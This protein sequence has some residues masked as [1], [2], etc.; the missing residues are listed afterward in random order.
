MARQSLAVEAT[1]R[2][3]RR[4]RNE[5]PSAEKLK[6]ARTPAMAP[7]PDTLAAAASMLDRETV[8]QAAQALLAHRTQHQGRQA[9]RSGGDGEDVLEANE[10]WVS[11]V[12]S[13]KRAPKRACLKPRTIPLLHP[14][15]KEGEDDVCFFVKDPQRDIKDL[16]AEKGVRSVTKVLGVTKLSKRYG[17]HEGKREL[18]QLYDLFLVDDRVAKMMPRLLGNTF[19]RGKKMPLVVRMDRDV[20]GGIAKALRSTSFQ[21]STGTTCNLRVAKASF[22]AEEIADNVES[23]VQGVA[24]ALPGEW[25]AFQGL[26]IKTMASPSLPIFAGIPEAKD[27]VPTKE[28]AEAKYG[29]DRL[30]RKKERAKCAKMETAKKTLEAKLARA[31]EK[32]KKKEGGRVVLGDDESEEDSEEIEKA[33]LESFEAGDAESD[34]D[35]VADG[36]D[37]DGSDSDAEEADAED[38]D[39]GVVEEEDSE[40]EAEVIAKVPSKRKKTRARKET[41]NRPLVRRGK[42]QDGAPAPKKKVKRDVDAPSGKVLRGGKG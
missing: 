29:A 39:A 19:V 33:I 37:R 10:D 22:S 6:K 13:L 38:A 34:S 11:V 20:P 5:E 14:L 16:L 21:V 4:Q 30:K 23:A 26:Y 2:R 3:S 8:L 28:E 32:K 9:G 36:V 27:F 35:E 24:A 1:P 7:A 41:S 12:V 31:A 25:G 17:T 15:F 42:A 40:E 18:A